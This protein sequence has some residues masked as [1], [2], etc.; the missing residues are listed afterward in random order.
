MGPLS[1]FGGKGYRRGEKGG[2]RRGLGNTR[3]FPQAPDFPQAPVGGRGKG[4]RVSALSPRRGEKGKGE[5][6][7]EKKGEKAYEKGLMAFKISKADFKS[8]PP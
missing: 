2:N 1:P 3:I 6:E 8:G 7:I 4:Q 5:E